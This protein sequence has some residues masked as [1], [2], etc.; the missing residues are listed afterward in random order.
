MKTESRAKAAGAGREGVGEGENCSFSLGLKFQLGFS[1]HRVLLSF[2][3]V[4]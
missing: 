1:N 4:G 2:Q 3:L